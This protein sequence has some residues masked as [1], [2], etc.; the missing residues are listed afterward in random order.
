MVMVCLRLASLRDQSYYLGRRIRLPLCPPGRQTRTQANN[1]FAEFRR[2]VPKQN[3]LA[4]HH[5]SWIYKSTWRL[6]YDCLHVT[7]AI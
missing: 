2:A 4:G 3:K 6:V 7:L 1:I 5:N